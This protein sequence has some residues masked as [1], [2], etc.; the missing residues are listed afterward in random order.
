ML[1]PKKENPPEQPSKGGAG[2]AAWFA[3]ASCLVVGVALML[4]PALSE[5]RSGLLACIAAVFGLLTILTIRW[6]S[7]SQDNHSQDGH[8]YES[9]VSMACA[10]VAMFASALIFIAETTQSPILAIAS[11]AALGLPILV[12]LAVMLRRYKVLLAMIASAIALNILVIIWM[13][14]N[15]YCPE[16]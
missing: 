4:L 12:Y 9:A 3:I 16:C 13:A 10:S 2:I 6:Q 11:I 7:L 8:S 14:I 5:S 15:Y 1:S